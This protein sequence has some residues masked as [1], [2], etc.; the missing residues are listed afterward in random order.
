MCGQASQPRSHSF[1]EDALARAAEHT[2]SRLDAFHEF[3]WKSEIEL[4][5][6]GRF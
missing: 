3:R 2:S 6:F 5:G 4:N 1:G